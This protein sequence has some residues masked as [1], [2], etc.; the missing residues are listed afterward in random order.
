MKR[1]IP[2]QETALATIRI[3]IQGI[4]FVDEMRLCACISEAVKLRDAAK[5]K[6]VKVLDNH[7]VVYKERP[8]TDERFHQFAEPP[9][10]YIECVLIVAQ[11]C[12]TAKR[13]LN[14]YIF[15]EE[16]LENM[17]IDEQQERIAAKKKE[18]IAKCIMVHTEG[19][20]CLRCEYDGS[21]ESDVGMVHHVGND[22][23]SVSHKIDDDVRNCKICTPPI[24][25][26]LT[27]KHRR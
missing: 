13:Y 14:N 5:E 23:N 21:N 16:E 9:F 12:L 4:C 17:Q 19:R 22:G 20:E 18:N 7:N 11:C 25:F 6:F 10:A 8:V 26:L 1:T 15:T 27:E 3:L 2:Y 24:P